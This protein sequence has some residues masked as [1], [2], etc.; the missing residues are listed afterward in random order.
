MKTI[1]EGFLGIKYTPPVQEGKYKSEMQSQSSELLFHNLLDF[2][3]VNNF[4]FRCR[5]DRDGND[6]GWKQQSKII[7]TIW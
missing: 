2:H 5:S 4:I 6:N 7:R 3:Q 1:M